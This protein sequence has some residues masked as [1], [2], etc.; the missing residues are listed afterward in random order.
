MKTLFYDVPFVYLEELF[1][2]FL[3]LSRLFTAPKIQKKSV[4]TVDNR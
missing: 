4:P 1:H 2:G 3:R